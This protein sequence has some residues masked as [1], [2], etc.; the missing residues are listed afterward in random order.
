MLTQGFFW[1]LLICEI[2][3]IGL[4]LV[5]IVSKVRGIWKNYE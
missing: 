4:L 5:A 1:F 3:A 2:A